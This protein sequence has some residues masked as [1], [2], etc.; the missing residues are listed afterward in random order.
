MVELSGIIN[1]DFLTKSRETCK[2]LVS[3][4]FH[5]GEEGEERETRSLATVHGVD[6][7]CTLLSVSHCSFIDV[8]VSLVFKDIDSEKPMMQVGQYV[9]A[10]EYEGKPRA[11]Q[12]KKKK[13]C[14]VTG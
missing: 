2:I 9:F 6:T 12:K 3:F 10:G 14:H 8:V 11:I 5:C 1:N 13:L 7:L 4:G